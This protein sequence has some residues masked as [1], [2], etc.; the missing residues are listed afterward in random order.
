MLGKSIVIRVKRM[1]SQITSPKSNAR[2]YTARKVMKKERSDSTMLKSA[3][4]WRRSRKLTKNLNS[5]AFI[6]RL[7]VQNLA[8]KR[9]VAIQNRR[10]GKLGKS[11]EIRA[12]RM[13]RQLT[14]PK[15]NARYTTRQALKKE[16]SDSTMLNSTYLWRRSRMLSKN[17]NYTAFSCR[18][19]V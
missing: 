2:R 4:L 11:I 15:S 18:L 6:S 8:L 5:T 1:P 3:Y 9:Q 7:Q 10:N 14:S 13:P 19:Q 16:S 17:L 12:K